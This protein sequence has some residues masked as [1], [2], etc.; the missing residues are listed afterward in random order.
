MIAPQIKET[1]K[2]IVKPHNSKSVSPSK[3]LTY[4]HN[5]KGMGFGTARDNV[6]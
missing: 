5:N 1:I 6:K 3:S 2:N 4:I